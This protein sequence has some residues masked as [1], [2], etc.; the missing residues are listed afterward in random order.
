VAYEFDWR[1]EADEAM[2][3]LEADPGMSSVVAAI[4]R[5]LDLLED[6]PFSPRLG[7]IQFQTPEFGGV[8]ATPVRVDGWYI[9]WQR[10][11]ESGILDIILVHE[12]DVRR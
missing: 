12:L 7:T 11:P 8:C 4:E 10:G 9:I 3:A 2:D 5:T 1:R 6:D